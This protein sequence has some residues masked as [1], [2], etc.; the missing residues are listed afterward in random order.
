M[1]VEAIRGFCA[2]EGVRGPILVG[3][4]GGPDSTALLVGLAEAG[5]GPLTAMY[6]DHG[7]R[8]GTDAEAELVRG[9][10][11]RVG[12]GFERAL[13]RVAAGNVMARAREA[14]YAAL[15]ERARARGVSLVAVG[16]TAN[17]QAETV[18][19]RAARGD[20]AHA[21]SGIPAR[22]PLAPGI[23]LIRPILAVAR[24]AVAGYVA[25]RGLPTAKDPSNDRP[26]FTRVRIRNGL[27]GVDAV[28]PLTALAAEAAGWVADLDARARALG[29]IDRMAAAEVAAAGV[30]VAIRLLRRAGLSRAGGAHGRALIALCSSTVGSRSIDLGEGLQAERRYDRIRIGARA[31]ADPGDL[32]V[33]IAGAGCYE[34]LGWTVTVQD[35]GAGGLELR[36]ARPGDRFR[37]RAGRRKLSDLFCDRK[38]P[39]AERRRVPLLARGGEVAWAAPF[40]WAEGWWREGAILVSPSENAGFEPH[41]GG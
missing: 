11:A 31:A 26:E 35:A 32:R 3:C 33:A 21:L 36:N 8:A 15:A 37:T 38:L 23:D 25:D 6:V 41:L 5:I 30:D 39:R 14:R 40:G 12:A 17:D 27:A 1:V 10:A 13:T 19:F 34:L 16:H 24:E 2:R 18:L 22:R 7:L 4:S 9:L 28:A 20:L 29:P